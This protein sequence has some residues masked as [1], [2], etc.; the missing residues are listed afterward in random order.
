M[1]ATNN[2]LYPDKNIVHEWRN[3]TVYKEVVDVEDVDEFQTYVA[4]P[5]KQISEIPVVANTA[6]LTGLDGHNLES[7]RKLLDVG[8]PSVFIGGEGSHRHEDGR[9][10]PEHIRKALSIRLGRTALATNTILRSD[11]IQSFDA[12]DTEHVVFAGESRG[13]MTS[14]AAEARHDS[15]RVLYSDPVAPAMLEHPSVRDLLRYASQVPAEIG[16]GIRELTRMKPSKAWRYLRTIKHPL[17]YTPY[18]LATAPALIWSNL[19]KHVET[20]DKNTPR[21]IT[22]FEKDYWSQPE[23][24]E[25]YFEDHPDTEII[26]EPGRHLKLI[27]P[28]I[29][30]ETRNRIRHVLY[31]VKQAQRNGTHSFESVAL[32]GIREYRRL[33]AEVDAHAEERVA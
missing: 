22:V 7:I 20:L 30:T 13:G 1:R 23:R 15:P 16:T 17:T 31:E 12:I 29:T 3:G 26:K 33:K 14:L 2:E 19:A 6:Y 28:A 32:N 8:V 4:I 11:A 18:A 25:Y 10:W 24:W 21:T 27:R 5:N 9:S